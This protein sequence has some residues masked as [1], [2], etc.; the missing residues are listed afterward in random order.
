MTEPVT[1]NEATDSGRRQEE[2]ACEP[3]TERTRTVKI[4]P[5]G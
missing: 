5:Q 4:F 3:R 1:K 2:T